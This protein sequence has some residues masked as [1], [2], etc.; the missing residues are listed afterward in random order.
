[1]AHLLR[2]PLAILALS[3][4]LLWL[5]AWVGARALPRLHARVAE[6]REEF[7]IVL[8]ATLTLLG[9]IIG[10]TFSMA[11][12][13]YDQ[14]KNLEEAEAN[15]IGTEYLRADLLPAQ[16]A[17]AVRA[18]LRDYVGLRLAYYVTRDADAL[19]GNE[20]ATAGMQRQM[21]A[22][23]RAPVVAAP[24]PVNALVAAGMNDVIN[25]QGYTQAAWTN[26]IPAAAWFLLEG[27]AVCAVLLV[28]LRSAARAGGVL[29]VLPLVVSVAL[30]LVAD[31]DSPRRGLIRVAP[32]NLVAL[33]QQLRAQ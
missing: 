8:G 24:N 3:F 14:R 12:A 2:S 33:A 4:G 7:D 9:L 17:T 20:G 30:F 22:A 19:R 1:M 27:M 13:R 31:I 16:D 26:R 23:V 21:W 15:A 28:G 25:A 10:F 6:S 29:L 11:L 18:L 5:A 32:Q